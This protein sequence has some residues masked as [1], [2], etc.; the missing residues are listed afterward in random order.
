M[1]Y[2]SEYVAAPGR[3]LQPV[4][5][6]DHQVVDVQNVGGGSRVMEVMVRSAAM[7]RGVLRG[8]QLQ[9]RR[10]NEWF[11]AADL[12]EHDD[13]GYR[14]LS[15]RGEG[16]KSGGCWVFPQR[17]EEALLAVPGVLLAAAVAVETEEG[18]LRV[19]A[20]AVLAPG[21]DQQ[22]WLSRAAQHVGRLRPKALKPES[23]RIV[24]TL[25][26]TPTGK[27]LRRALAATPPTALRIA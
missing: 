25:P 14:F 18:L 9:P 2:F 24:S 3:G 7:M 23:I 19:R 6:F 22:E 17:V 1:P 15:R 27:M 21:T 8:G 16:F 12:F 13:G 26:V 10:P 11:A 20:Y 4:P 5:A